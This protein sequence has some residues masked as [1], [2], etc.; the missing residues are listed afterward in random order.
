MITDSL[1]SS[2]VAV[3]FEHH[4]E[5][6]G[7]GE[8]RPR[9]SWRVSAEVS[10]WVQQAYE[11]EV[12]DQAGG[13]V[14]SGGR[15]ES[16][17]SV[18]VPWE[19]PVLDSRARRTVRVRVWGAG[20]KAPSP[21][22]EAADVEVGL[23]RREDWSAAL[24]GPDRD[25]GDRLDR[26]PV[27]FR[28]AFELDGKVERARL[29]VT[30]HG[31]YAAEMNG[32][33]VGDH[34][35]APGWTSYHHRLRYQTFDVTTLVAR[36]ENVLGATVAEGWY[37]GHLGFHG[38]RR[39]IFGEDVAF[40]AQLEVC[41]ADGR[42]E[43]LVTDGEWRWA[44]GPTIAAGI[45]AGETYDARLER[46][47]WS[48]TGYDDSGW[49]AV[50]KLGPETA[51]LVAP[52]GPPIRRI[53]EIRPVSIAR[54]P[55][56]RTI[57]D[58]G[59]NL[60]GR[61]RLRVRGDTATTITLRHAEVLEDGEIATRPLR[62]AA[63]TDRY[64][65]KGGGEFEEW[66]P[67]F[68]YHGF[69]YVDVDGW[70][71]TRSPDNLRAVVIHTDMARTGWFDCSEP[72]LNRLHENVL[73]TMRGNFMDIPTD[74]P[75]RDERLGWPGDLGVF[76][77]TATFL[78]DCA[79]LLRSWLA[80][81]AI[82]Q[83]AYGTVPLYVPWFELSFPLVPVAVW[84][85]AAVLVPWIIY[86]RFGDLGVLRDQYDSMK[87]WVDQVASI[88][89]EE[90]LWKTGLQL[91][92]WLDPAA[93][94]DAP[95]AALTDRY[96]VATAY[97][98]LTARLLADAARLLGRDDDAR[99]YGDLAAAVRDAFDREYVSPAGR[100]VSDAQTAYTL[101]LEFD[102]MPGEAQRKRAGS[103]LA[104]LVRANDHRAG[105]GFVGSRLVCDALT[106]AGALDTAYHMLLQQACPSWLYP[107]TMGATTIWERWDSMLPN[108]RLNPGDMLSF[109]HCALGAIADW[110]HRT[111]AG[112]APAEPGYR[113]IL[114][115]PR[116][117]GGLAHAS[118]AHETPY[119]RAEVAWVRSGGRLEVDIAVPAGAVATVSLPDPDWTEIEVGSGRHR[120][121]CPFR[122]PEDDPPRPAA[123]SP[124]GLQPVGES[125]VFEG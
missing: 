76:A 93:P 8:S 9:I 2:V 120:F 10:G 41:Y 5:P 123:P 24:I 116:P 72:L 25:E 74:C 29:Y 112:L 64:T 51:Q 110:L 56:G 58:F 59:Q 107:V 85:D 48:A 44:S 17:E 14:W 106:D 37:S 71:G 21:W 88:A 121:G 122:R 66:E 42:T 96:L 77:P 114:I 49:A 105:T 50:R 15:V 108:G 70:P 81:I 57:V 26:P 20:D 86:E 60:V 97:H 94:A 23:M 61:V 28:R 111:V 115:A 30:A 69:R 99:R 104:E 95:E 22:S 32:E 67:S 125:G 73:W 87:A 84:G 109:N 55:S 6:F 39:R 43:T 11:I 54:S 78:Y 45:Y 27:L 117:G 83:R 89:G 53:E 38:G 101:A 1:A 98:A 68:T 119:G 82:E 92:D 40:L 91:G 65:L 47:G 7:I 62:G 34:V 12:A 52:A 36:G 75:Q 18:L 13:Q 3:C 90:H 4:R 102:L 80:D 46:A 19:A 33:R 124:L 16:A 31:V 100:V 79:G 103:R 113:R 118:A 63:A 35:L